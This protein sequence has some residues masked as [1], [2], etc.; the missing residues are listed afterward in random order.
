MVPAIGHEGD[1]RI[2]NSL[3]HLNGRTVA[4][5]ILEKQTDLSG[6]FSVNRITI[7]WPPELI[8]ILLSR[9]LLE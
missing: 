1:K 4:D 6:I 5:L 7:P 9:G 3:T 2:I 8:R